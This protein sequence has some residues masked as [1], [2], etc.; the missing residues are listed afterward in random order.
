MHSRTRTEAACLQAAV[1]DLHRRSRSSAAIARRHLN[2]LPSDR[3]EA[4]EEEWAA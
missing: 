1:A 4:L 2:R 3:R